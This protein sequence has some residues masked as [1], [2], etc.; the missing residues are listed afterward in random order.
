MVRRLTSTSSHAFLIEMVCLSAIASTLLCVIGNR[1][2]ARR[3]GASGPLSTLDKTYRHCVA[4]A[5]ASTYTRR[6]SDARTVDVECYAGSRGEETPRRFTFKG[7]FVE[8]DT[9]V[10]Q[11]RTPDHRCFKVRIAAGESYTLRQ[12]VRLGAWDL[13][14]VEG[15]GAVFDLGQSEEET[16]PRF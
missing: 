1:D 3:T 7:R 13:T 5:A 6:V 11:W 12:D 4:A 15:S 14:E 10:D 16:K 9:V 2:R 8:V